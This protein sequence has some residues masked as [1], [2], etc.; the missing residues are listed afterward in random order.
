MHHGV[1]SLSLGIMC[2]IY[3][4]VLSLD[5]SEYTHGERGHIATPHGETHMY[6]VQYRFKENGG[7]RYSKWF[8]VSRHE[9]VSEARDALAQHIVEFP[10]FNAR[11]ITNE[12]KTLGDYKYTGL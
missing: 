7:K 9:I 8:K 1:N 11:L 5:A 4:C 2:N 12:G 6:T 10:S 3:T